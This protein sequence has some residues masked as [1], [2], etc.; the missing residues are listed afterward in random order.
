[1]PTKHY[2]CWW[3]TTYATHRNNAQGLG[4][5]TTLFKSIDE[6]NLWT[7]FVEVKTRYSLELIQ[8]C[9]AKYLLGNEELLKKY[10]ASEK[11]LEKS[12]LESLIEK[13][14]IPNL[15]KW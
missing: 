8:D 6:H 7:D 11:P 5:L 9:F 3:F 13:D 14:L 2:L 15:P 1:M 12:S 4:H 10:M